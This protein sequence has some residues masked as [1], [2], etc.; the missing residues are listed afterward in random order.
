MSLLP[1]LLLQIGDRKERVVLQLK[2]LKYK[3]KN[4]SYLLDKLKANRT[5]EKKTLS[6]IRRL[7]RTHDTFV[8]TELLV[9]IYITEK[10]A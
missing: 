2:Q 6:K 3:G 9:R 10:N 1:H 8:C 5:V 4:N 7:I